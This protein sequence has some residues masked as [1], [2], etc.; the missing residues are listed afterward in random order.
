MR[1]G[2]ID[3]IY[4][5]ENQMNN[6]AHQDEQPGHPGNDRI[7]PQTVG[8][9]NRRCHHEEH[10]GEQRM[11]DTAVNGSAMKQI[12]GA[13]ANRGEHRQPDQPELGYGIGGFEVEQHREGEKETKAGE[14]EARRD[15][16]FQI[17]VGKDAADEP[18]RGERQEIA[19]RHDIRS[20]GGRSGQ[21]RAD[22]APAQ[23]CCKIRHILSSSENVPELMRF[24]WGARSR[25]VPRT[26]ET[27]KPPQNG[28]DGQGSCG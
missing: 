18:R 21:P 9:Q 8:Q 16:F 12:V 17:D 2:E 3:G 1:T 28:L 10:A 27:R 5:V 14:Q 11:E 7:A 22:R 25:P 6:V 20:I 24:E 26:Q 4:F 15:G 19:R 13:I 23:M